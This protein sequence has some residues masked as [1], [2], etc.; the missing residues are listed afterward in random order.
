MQ[1]EPT[2]KGVRG[3][4]PLGLLRSSLMG[5]FDSSPPLANERGTRGDQGRAPGAEAAAGWLLSALNPGV[6]GRTARE[7]A[8]S[9]GGSVSHF[10]ASSTSSLY[11]IN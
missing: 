1:D 4:L 6:R 8:R 3:F 11:A 10:F 2:E 7:E 5:L 9:L